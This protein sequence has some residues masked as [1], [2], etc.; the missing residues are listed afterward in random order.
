[1]AVGLTKGVEDVAK[2]AEL[3]GQPIGDQTEVKGRRSGEATDG[4]LREHGPR[5]QRWDIGEATDGQPSG[6]QTE[7]GKG[8]NSQDTA[9]VQIFA[10]QTV[11]PK[12]AEGSTTSQAHSAI[13]PAVIQSAIFRKL[14]DMHGNIEEQNKIDHKAKTAIEIAMAQGGGKVGSTSG[15]Q[16]TGAQTVAGKGRTTLAAQPVGPS[17]RDGK[18][19]NNDRESKVTPDE[20]GYMEVKRKGKPKG[21]PVSQNLTF[22]LSK[23][24]TLISKKKGQSNDLLP[25]KN[26]EDSTKGTN[27]LSSSK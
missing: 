8:G 12:E 15:G 7:A 27:P 17:A 26:N 1:M 25:A 5:R 20:D 22:P 24:P 13:S 23:M 18:G 9:K 6:T 4:R 21:N 10:P 2:G 19:G 16:P 11:R 14:A 3:R